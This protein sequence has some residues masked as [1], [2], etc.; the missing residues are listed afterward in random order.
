VAEHVQCGDRRMERIEK[1]V[2]LQANST[3]SRSTTTSVWMP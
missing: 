1:V 3:F 2:E